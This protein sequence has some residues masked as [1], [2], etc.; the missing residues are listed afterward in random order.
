MGYVIPPFNS[1]Y[2]LHLYVQG[3]PYTSAVKSLMYQVSAGTSD[4]NKGFSWSVEVDQAISILKK[5][6]GVGVFAC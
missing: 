5:G 1:I 2:H 3:L 4:N 6:R